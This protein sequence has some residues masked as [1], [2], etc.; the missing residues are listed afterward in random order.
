MAT[1]GDIQRALF[2]AA[3]PVEPAGTAET[4]PAGTA[5]T[6]PGGLDPERAE[7]DVTWVRVLKSRVPAFDVLEPGD[8]AIV[9]GPALAAIAPG[10]SG[11]EE[12]ATTLEQA[13]VPAVL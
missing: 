3:R 11:V 1:L 7:R 5:D 10:G 8:L 2:P 9:P 4:G 12:L 6:G 13:E